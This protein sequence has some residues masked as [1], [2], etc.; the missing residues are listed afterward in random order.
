[1]N[2]DQPVGNYW[3]RA[4]PNFGLTGFENGVNTA[5]LRYVG[6]PPIDPKTKPNNCSRLLNEVDLHPLE[7]PG[8]VRS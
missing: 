7:H 4:E 3:I 1:M 2:A 5:I 6:A 8:A